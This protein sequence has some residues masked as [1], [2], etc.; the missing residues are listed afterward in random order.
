M[1]SKVTG[2]TTLALLL[3]ACTAGPNYRRPATVADAAPATYKSA[4]G[5]V[6]AQPADDRPRADW[7]TMF[8]DPVLSDLEARVQRANQDV[9]A[10]VAAYDQAQ[11]LV[12]EQRAAL[13]PTVGLTGG[14]TRSGGGGGGGNIV[15]SGGTT[16]VSSGGGSQSRFSLG[17]SASWTPDLFGQ[18]RRGIEGARASAR[19][20][21][22]DLANIVLASQGELANNYVALRSLDAQAKLYDATT[23]AYARALKIARNRYDVGVAARADVVQAEGPAQGRTGQRHR[24]ATPARRL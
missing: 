5:W 19:A 8:D 23:A 1:N 2:I 21:A 11:A 4:P 6:P 24:P 13:F 22:A 10:A 7:W 14:A 3:G 20:S 12:R 9:A 15:T 16:T 17:V 18:V